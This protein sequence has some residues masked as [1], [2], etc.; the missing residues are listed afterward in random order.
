MFS[1]E[2]KKQIANAVQEI[3]RNTNDSELPEGEIEF[4]LYVLGKESWSWAN[5]RNN[6][7]IS[8]NRD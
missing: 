8:S 3:L 4:N 6:G 1:P 2:V 7:A 5:I